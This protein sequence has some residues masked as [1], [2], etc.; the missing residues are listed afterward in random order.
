MK[1]TFTTK[2][3]TRLLEL[4]HMGLWAAGARSEDPNSMP[5]RYADLSQKLFGMADEFG[6][7]TLIEADAE[8]LL[9]PGPAL[10]NGPVREKLDHC[11]DDNFWSELVSRLAERDLRTDLQLPPDAGE[12]MSGELEERLAEMEDGYWKEFEANGVDRLF[13]LKGGQG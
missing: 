1:V 5:E 13:L 2:E 12:D 11:I 8:G 3:Y 6:C 9:F 4:V 10:E 7:S